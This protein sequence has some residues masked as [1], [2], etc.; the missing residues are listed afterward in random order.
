M[1]D[2]LASYIYEIV[3]YA[4]SMLMILRLFLF[5]IPKLFPMITE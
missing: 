2:F 4:L 1:D 3:D 5:A